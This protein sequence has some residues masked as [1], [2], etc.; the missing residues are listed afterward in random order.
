MSR[1]HYKQEENIYSSACIQALEQ[2]Y[3]SSCSAAVISPCL[4]SSH[5]LGA[6][7]M[8]RIYDGGRKAVYT[9]AVGAMLANNMVVPAYADP[10]L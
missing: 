6:R 7:I 3:C 9:A 4:V 10:G 5:G 8:S 2:E 1:H